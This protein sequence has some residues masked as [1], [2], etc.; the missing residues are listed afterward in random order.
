MSELLSS[1][2]FGDADELS[3]QIAS[4]VGTVGMNVYDNKGNL[5]S[6]LELWD[7]GEGMK[8]LVIK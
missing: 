5:L 4:I 2:I 3:E 6:K 7:D 8:R 1:R